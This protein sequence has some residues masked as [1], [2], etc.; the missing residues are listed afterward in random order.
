MPLYL[1][2][3][4]GAR[5]DQATPV[6]ASSDPTVIAAVLQAVSQ[7]AEAGPSEAETDSAARDGWRVLPAHEE[8]NGDAHV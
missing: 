1:T 7:L 2:L 4:R 5:A 8:D 6:L 3:S